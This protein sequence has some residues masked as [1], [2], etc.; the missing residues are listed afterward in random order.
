MTSRRFILA[1]SRC[2]RSRNLSSS[3]AVRCREIILDFSGI[4]ARL[5]FPGFEPLLDGPGPVTNTLRAPNGGPTIY[6]L[7]GDYMVAKRLEP[8]RF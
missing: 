6:G 8:I 5:S 7:V 4:W 3:I 1:T 2:L